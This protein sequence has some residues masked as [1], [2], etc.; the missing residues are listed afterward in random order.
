MVSAEADAAVRESQELAALLDAVKEMLPSGVE[1][2]LRPA[3]AAARRPIARR[4]VDNLG[5]PPGLR[6]YRCLI[7]GALV[8]A[9]DPNA[10]LTTEVYPQIA[11]AV[12]GTW[13]Q[14]ERNMR[15]AI[16]S[17][18][19]RDRLDFCSVMGASCPI[20]PNVGT[21]LVRLALLLREMTSLD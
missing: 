19:R 14:A 6:G 1:F 13:Q 5:V 3:G 21:V 9:N 16:G 8:V 20:P 12:G 4:L 2:V 7:E 17:A 11:Q 15:H 18:L 10:S